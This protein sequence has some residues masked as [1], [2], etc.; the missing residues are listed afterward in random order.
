M[1][2][3]RFEKGGAIEIAVR[4]RSKAFAAGGELI[5]E[6]HEL[7]EICLCVLS[8]GHTLF[9]ETVALARGAGIL[10]EKIDNNLEDPKPV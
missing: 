8:I 7:K 3:K 6:K 10:K 4:E 5:L 2:G 9:N 1:I